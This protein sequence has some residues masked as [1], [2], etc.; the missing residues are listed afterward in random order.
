MTVAPAP[1]PAAGGRHPGTPGGRTARRAAVATLVATVLGLV[2]LGGAAAAPLEPV[3]PAPPAFGLRMVPWGATP[4]DLLDRARAAVSAL[5]FRGEVQV[6]WSER[7][8]RRSVIVPVVDDAGVLW[9]GDRRAVG[10]GS[11]RLLETPR[12]GW[13]ELWSG[14]PT[15][16]G[17]SGTGGKYVLRIGGSTTVAGRPATTVEAVLLADATVRERVH[18]DD[19]TGL[20]LR[21]DDL[22]GR[23][24]VIRSVG[25]RRI[26][27][28]APAEG[29]P[30]SLP[31]VGVAGPRPRRVD[32]VPTP[33][34]APERAGHGFVLVD[35]LRHPGGDVQLFYSDGVF[36]LS[37]FEQRGVLDRSA[38]PPGGPPVEAAGHRART[39]RTPGGTTLVW[40]A[41]GVVYTC[42]T[43]APASEIGP[44]LASFP[45]PPAR[46]VWGRITDFV[47]RPF[48]WA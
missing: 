12:G 24:E 14:A 3:D 1:R 15:D 48:R 36:S 26:S 34:R 44:I 35:Q 5:S 8:G 38:L 37:V 9:V 11:T 22:D 45:S 10:A 19:A 2:P 20:V 40:E 46:S 23:G 16:E 39:Y 31:P 43:D 18:L 28:L 41:S 30:P 47:L 13:E 4:R 32:R 6:S 27:G 33:F 25:F 7:G 42:V 29:E 17:G 21:R